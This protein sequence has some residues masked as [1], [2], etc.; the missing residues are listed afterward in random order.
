MFLEYYILYQLKKKI[1]DSHAREI[2]QCLNG[3]LIILTVY[4]QKINN[5]VYFDFYAVKTL[6][7]SFKYFVK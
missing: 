4:K 5:Q 1:H 7:I 2:T 6:F 3:T